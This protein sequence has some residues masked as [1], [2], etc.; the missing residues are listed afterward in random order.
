MSGKTWI[1]HEGRLRLEHDENYQMA[2]PP[3]ADDV[4]LKMDSWDIDLASR[5]IV[6]GY[7]E[8]FERAI[9]YGFKHCPEG[10]TGRDRA[11]A[12]ITI[13]SQIFTLAK[14]AVAIGDIE[15]HDRPA[16]WIAWA[17]RKGY[18]TDHLNPTI[19]IEG[20]KHALQNCPDDCPG[21]RESYREQLAQWQSPYLTLSAAVEQAAPVAAKNTTSKNNGEPPGKMPNTGIGKLAIKAAWKIEC[22]SKKR[23]TVDEVIKMLQ[24]WVKSEPELLEVIKNGVVWQTQGCKSKPFDIDACSK[25]LEAWHKSRA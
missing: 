5:L 20:F 11:H 19:Q 7:N 17:Q 2:T 16:N 14:A 23:A 13:M 22:E 1:D 4:W 3:C 18:K 12:L 24:E 21:V 9:D 25:A 6:L 10:S 8:D 15:E